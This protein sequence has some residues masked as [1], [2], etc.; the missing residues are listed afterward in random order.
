M[1]HI[2]SFLQTVLKAKMK[3][4]PVHL[5][6]GKESINTIPAEFLIDENGIVKKVHYARRLNDELS[7]DL[8]SKFADTGAIGN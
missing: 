7:L 5:M 6:K 8:I 4:L 2:T 1:C 3:R